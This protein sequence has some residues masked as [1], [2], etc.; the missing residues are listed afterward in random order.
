MYDKYDLHNKARLWEK[1]HTARSA[2]GNTFSFIKNRG[3]AEYYW[4][5]GG[6]LGG[7]FLWPH[8]AEGSAGGPP[9]LRATCHNI[10]AGKQDTLADNIF[11]LRGGEKKRTERLFRK[12]EIFKGCCIVT[13]EVKKKQLQCRLL[14]LRLWQR[15]VLSID[16]NFCLFP[17]RIIDP[18]LSTCANRSPLINRKNKWRNGSTCSFWIG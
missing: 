6:E 4:G 2:A 7:L 14:L 10:P 13:K 18:Q 11:R 5:V 15:S 9:P 12:K 8:R 1:D 3:R 17:G 16:L